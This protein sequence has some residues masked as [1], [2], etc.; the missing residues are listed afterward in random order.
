M[1]GQVDVSALSRGLFVLSFSY[2]EDLEMILSGGPW[3]FGKSSLS[4][5]KWSPNME[6][7]D[8]FFESAPVWMRLPGLPLEFWL[9][10]VFLGIANSFGELVAI[11]PMIEA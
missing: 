2:G 4:L 5:R 6:L 8:F 9:E 1:K 7:N 10:D 11:D 3:M